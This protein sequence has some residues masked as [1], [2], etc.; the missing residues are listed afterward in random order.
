MALVRDQS[1]LS[2]PGLSSQPSISNGHSACCNQ[3]KTPPDFCLAGG[4]CYSQDGA[5]S[6]RRFWALGCT[7][8][9]GKDSACQRYC[10]TNTATGLYALNARS[11]GTWCCND[12][13]GDETCCNKANRTNTF[14]LDTVLSLHPAPSQTTPVGQTSG[15]GQTPT[16]TQTSTSTTTIFPNTCSDAAGATVSSCPADIIPG[17]SI[18]SAIGGC[19]LTLVVTLLL[20]LRRKSRRLDSPPN[21]LPQPTANYTGFTAAASSTPEFEQK[22]ASYAGV[23][24]SMSG[25]GAPRGT[26]YEMEGASGY[27]K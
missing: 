15:G 1:R 24:E 22:E 11:D 27:G 21:L 26:P 7:D 20:L 6:N 2:H 14:R 10:P 4:F 13:T 9:T 19:L 17:A 8:S 16:V 25:L 5:H 23:R 3:G 12:L 18:W